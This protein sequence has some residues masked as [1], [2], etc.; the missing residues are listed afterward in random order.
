MSVA[1]AVALDTLKFVR[2]PQ[3]TEVDGG[4]VSV[5]SETSDMS[6][7]TGWKIQASNLSPIFPFQAAFQWGYTLSPNR[8]PPGLFRER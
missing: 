2:S 1:V 3:N 5:F 6:K 8:F 7:T 4:Y